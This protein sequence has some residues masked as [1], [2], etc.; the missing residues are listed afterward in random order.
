ML[1]HLRERKLEMI[2]KDTLLRDLGRIIIWYPF[3]WGILLLSLSIVIKVGR[4]MGKI[5]SL[6]NRKR[7]VIMGQNIQRALR[8]T[9]KEAH[10]I[11]R[12]NLELHYIHLLELFKFPQLSTKN[13]D[14]FVELRGLEHL[15]SCL[16]HKRGVILVHL[17]FGTMQIPL[18][19]LG[20]KGY[21][22]NQIGQR[23]P[24]NNN[25]SFIHRKV[26]LRQR[27]KI[28]ATIPADIINIGM[29]S[30][31]RPAFR[32]LE[33]NEV[34]MIT[35]DG[36]GGANPVGNKY[37]IVDFLGQKTHFPPGPVTIARKTGA[38]MLPLFCFR[39]PDGRQRVEIHPPLPL[40]FGPN[41][42]LDIHT[43][44]QLYADALS[45]EV[46]NHPEH[47]MFWQEFTPG[48][49]ICK[50]ICFNKPS[51]KPH[52]EFNTGDLH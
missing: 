44:T 49:M 51:P 12:L 16:E 9:P 40:S 42:E 22:M 36:R 45:K 19:A 17:H 8:C 31:L 15:D 27:L 2:I 3:R 48:L 10:H 1:C 35:G 34:L 38:K 29:T 25:L 11:A 18:I 52:S 4:I 37:I 26:A 43:N 39:L 7:I 5:E 33:Q 50:E 20:H 28:E 13:I 47:W 23:E 24:D 46:T 32:C 30:T 41:K 14:H 21:C 6:Y